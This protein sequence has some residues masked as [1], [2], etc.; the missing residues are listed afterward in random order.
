MS[1]LART[2][3]V[4]PPRAT[5]GIVRTPNKQGISYAL[6]VRY[7]G[8]RY[9][10]TKGG[11]WEGWDDER[12]EVERA[13]VA[14]QV[15]R[16]E[17]LP[18][19]KRTERRRAQRPETQPGRSARTTFRVYGSILLAKWARNLSKKGYA[20]VEW[21]LLRAITHI[22]D[23]AIEDIDVAMLEEMVDAFLHEREA[24]RVAAEAGDPLMEEIT[25][26]RNRTYKRK[27]KS[28]D[29]R[30]IMRVLGGVS[31]VLDHAKRRGLIP[32]NPAE[33]PDLQLVVDKPDR[34]WLQPYQ[35]A[36][37]LQAARDVEAEARALTLDQVRQIRSPAHGEVSNVVL[38]RRFG[39]SDSLVSRVRRGVEYAD[40]GLSQRDVPRHA[41]SQTLLLTGMRI[42]EKC[43]LDGEH[44]D[45]PAARIMVPG[46]KTDAAERVVPMMP[47]LRDTLLEHRAQRPYGPQDP[48]YSTSTGAR[49]TPDNV[50]RRLIEPVR[51]RANQILAKQ[52]RPLIG[53]VTPHTF[54]RTFASILAEIGVSERR[55]MYLLG[56]SDPRFTLRVYTQVLEMGGDGVELLEQ[57]L[58]TTLDDARRIYSGRSG[59]RH[60]RAVTGQSAEAETS[61]GLPTHTSENPNYAD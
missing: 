22:G 49:N 3:G 13:Y 59:G 33:D 12:I 52:Q 30:S 6:R 5:V 9:F 29:N 21:Q 34:S 60:D 54:R 43:L 26:K 53:R 1:A 14:A 7:Q 20:D 51:E 28:L 15:A 18:P 41:W 25:D 39:V 46:T 38:A 32:Y 31:R 44:M 11:D 35:I 8:E 16:G 45:F 17:W 36:A 19:A 55:C 42:E 40:D 27:R 47:A 4:M 57:V 50:R 48:V 23:E 10:I 58:G 2:I 61:D 37:W 56:H 24:I